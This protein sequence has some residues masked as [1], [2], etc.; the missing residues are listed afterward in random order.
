MSENKVES[1]LLYGGSKTFWQTRSCFNITIL[2]HGMHADSAC[3]VIEVIA[4]DP[5]K[6]NEQRIYLDKSTLVDKVE[7][8]DLNNESEVNTLA[9]HIFLDLCTK[10]VGSNIELSLKTF[11]AMTGTIV[12]A[13]ATDSMVIS[14]ILT[15]DIAVANEPSSVE[16]SPPNSPVDVKFGR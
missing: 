10:V 6:D 13:G 9:Q 14:R 7:N 11:K 2:E 1:R 4:Y 3:G 12:S 16:A 15:E 5:V 8:M